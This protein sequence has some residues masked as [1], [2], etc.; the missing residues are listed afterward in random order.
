MQLGSKPEGKKK[1]GSELGFSASDAV[2]LRPAMSNARPFAFAGK[3]SQ[4]GKG[5]KKE[6]E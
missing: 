4:I 2:G 1:G 3:N 5:K 6:E